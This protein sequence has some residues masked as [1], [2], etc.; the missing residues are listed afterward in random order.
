M[1]SQQN[2]A[3]FRALDSWTKSCGHIATLAGNLLKK[4]IPYTFILIYYPTPP[5]R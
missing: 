4:R 5:K 3:G 1:T 2:A